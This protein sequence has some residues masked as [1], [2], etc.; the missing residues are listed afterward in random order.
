MKFIFL[1]LGFLSF[2]LGFIGV[3]LP[4]LPTTPFLLFSLFCFTKSSP[5]FEQKLI[6]SKIYKK[7]LEDFVKHRRLSIGRKIFLLC[8]ATSMLMFPLIILDTII[9]K[10]LIILLLIYLY[11]YFIFKIKNF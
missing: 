8:L 10:I 2:T 7:Y 4:I 9:I 5:K 6:N 3:F 11:Y 1:V